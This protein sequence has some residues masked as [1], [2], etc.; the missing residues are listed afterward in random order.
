MIG[1]STATAQEERELGQ[2]QVYNGT[3]KGKT[4]A[5]LGVVLRTIG[6]GLLDHR[7]RVLVIRFNSFCGGDETASIEAVQ[8]GFPGIV[9]RV[10]LGPSSI[11]WPV[12][13][14]AMQ[15]GRYSVVIL[16]DIV[17]AISS[18]EM[19]EQPVCQGIKNRA[20][21]VEVICTGEGNPG[22]LLA[23]ADLHTEMIDRP[24][25]EPVNGVKIYTG[26]GKGKSTNG[27]GTALRALGREERVLVL[28]FMKGGTGYT[29][30]AAIDALKQ[31]YPGSLDHMR[32]GRDAIVWRGQQVLDDYAEAERTWEVARS[33]VLGGLHKTVILDELNPVVDLELLPA[34]P[35]AELL[36]KKPNGV[37]VIITGRS[38]E[39]HSYFELAE[40]CTEMVCHRHYAE[41]GVALKRGIDY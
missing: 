27:L 26:P 7:A 20:A 28:Q 10:C 25:D 15:W 41:N 24:G 2:V 37:E 3:G 19:N 22:Q 18:G 31:A 36:R 21:G 38:H 5:A 13:K 40:A 32:S 6:L 33:A 16:D 17:R 30:D 12:A 29:E 39:R 23:M 35:I 14:Q 4:Q 9:D 11:N 8:H 1:I 34:P